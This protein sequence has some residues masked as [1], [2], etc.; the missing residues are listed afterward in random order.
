MEKFALTT[1]YLWYLYVRLDECVANI[2]DLLCGSV[3][4]CGSD[5]N[6]VPL[7]RLGRGSVSRQLDKD[8]TVDTYKSL[9]VA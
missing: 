1:L 6:E 9:E 8:E 7:G 3:L 4:Y 2:S 5:A